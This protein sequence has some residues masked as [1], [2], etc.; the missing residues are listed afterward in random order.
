MASMASKNMEKILLKRMSSRGQTT[1]HCFRFSNMV[2]AEAAT[3]AEAVLAAAAA[4]EAA[5]EAGSRRRLRS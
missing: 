1:F 2:E 3:E 4:E 5:V